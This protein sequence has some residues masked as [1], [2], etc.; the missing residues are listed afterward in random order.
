MFFV[1][2]FFLLL[3]GSILALYAGYEYYTR[4]LPDFTVVT[5]YKPKLKSEVYAAD[6]TLIGEIRRG[7]A[8]D[9]NVMRIYR[10]MSGTRLSLLRTGAFSSTK[11]ST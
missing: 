6:G 10:S 8:H 3:A 5:G 9:Y 4:D 7:E 11:G 2:S 1:V